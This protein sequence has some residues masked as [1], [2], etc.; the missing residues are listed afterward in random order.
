MKNEQIEF[1]NRAKRLLYTYAVA[2]LQKE[3]NDYMHSIETGLEN[4]MDKYGIEDFPAVI[5]IS[6]EPITG[7]PSHSFHFL[8]REENKGNMREYIWEK[9]METDSVIDNLLNRNNITHTTPN[10]N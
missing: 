8:E 9:L 4:I 1:N 7:R 3:I 2:E 10:E 5:T 6:E